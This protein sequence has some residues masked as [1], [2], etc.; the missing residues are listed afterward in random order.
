M[1]QGEL[2]Q[3]Q[4]IM[5]AANAHSYGLEARLDIYFNRQLS[6]FSMVN[7]QNGEEELDNGEKAALRHSAPFMFRGGFNYKSRNFRAE[8]YALYNDEVSNENL[9]PSEAEKDYMYAIDQNGNP[10]SPSWYTINAKAMYDFN[11]SMT[12][13]LGWENITNQR[14]RPYSSGIVAAGSNL[15][16]SVRYNF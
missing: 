12:V 9:S 8:I 5:N 13:S 11:Q 3:V 16:L 6:M 2:S 14:Y 7:F 15:I 4:T 10:Y 1:Y